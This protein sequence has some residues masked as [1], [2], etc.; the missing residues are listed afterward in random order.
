MAAITWRISKSCSGLQIRVYGIPR[1]SQ[2]DDASS[3]AV[4]RSHQ[5][6]GK[7]ERTAFQPAAAV[8]EEGV[9]GTV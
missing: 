8:I 5:F 7:V 6:G 4:G 3:L 1:F 2:L 9:A